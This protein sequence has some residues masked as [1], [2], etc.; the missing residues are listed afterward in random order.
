MGSRHDHQKQDLVLYHV[1]SSSLF[2]FNYVVLIADI[3]PATRFIKTF[4]WHLI[5]SYIIT[6]CKFQSLIITTKLICNNY[7]DNSLIVI[8]T[9]LR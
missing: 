5:N 4:K 2:T 6:T 3:I 1:M 7:I 8:K 9:V